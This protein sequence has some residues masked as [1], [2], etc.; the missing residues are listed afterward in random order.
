M[1][2]LQRLHG[3]WR[4]PLF[5]VPSAA[6]GLPLSAAAPGRCIY[7]TASEKQA[8]AASRSGLEAATVASVECKATA[9]TTSDCL[10]ASAKT[11]ASPAQSQGCDSQHAVSTH[12]LPRTAL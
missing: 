1:V 3:E 5:P 2:R 4:F 9:V 6:A 8:L 12:R 11:A 10:C 7:L